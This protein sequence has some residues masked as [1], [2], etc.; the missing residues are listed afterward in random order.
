VE[1][2]NSIVGAAERLFGAQ[3]YESTTT[4]Q[5]AKE[6]DVSVG[7]LYRYFAD[8]EAI[9]KELYRNDILEMRHRILA[10]IGVVDIVG[11]DARQLAHT[12]MALAFK[13]Y[14]DRPGIRRVLFEQSRKVPDLAALRKEQEA[15]LHAAVLQVINAFPGVKLPDLEVAAYLLSLFMESLIE[16][17]VLY[18]GPTAKFDHA[19]LIDTAAEFIVRSMFGEAD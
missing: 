19:R 7:A 13:I 2:R 3:G 15:R 11:K 5:I 14:S 12:A 16:D 6:A 1:T 4:H 8:K 17:V 9:L 10:E 18:G